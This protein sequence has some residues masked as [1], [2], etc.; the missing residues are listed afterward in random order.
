M[1]T[2][3]YVEG[4]P[5]GATDPK[6]LKT[7]SCTRPLKGLG[8]VRAGPLFHQYLCTGDPKTGKMT[9]GG[10]GPT[11]GTRPFDTSP[12]VNEP[13][14]FSP[15]KCEERADNNSCVEAC[16]QK[17]LN[18][19]LPQYDVLA[20][21]RLAKPE[22]QQCQIFAEDTLSSCVNQCLHKFDWRLIL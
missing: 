18:G 8:G 11:P 21:T 14:D 16:I 1:N 17:K 12:G 13:D 7:F 22:T 9:C 19:T 3:A 4:D 20:G 2:F 15:E 10:L 6:G 5:L